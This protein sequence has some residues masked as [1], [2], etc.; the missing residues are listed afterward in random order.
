MP[1]K[2]QLGDMVELKKNHPCGG[3][4]FEVM[5]TGMDFRLRCV[6]C[7]TQIWLSRPVLEKRLRRILP[8]NTG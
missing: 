8:D 7:N 2:I 4:L 1:I 6:K 5:R 3:N